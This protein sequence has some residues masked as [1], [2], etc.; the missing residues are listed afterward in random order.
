MTSFPYSIHIF[1]TFMLCSYSAFCTFNNTSSSNYPV[2]LSS[3]N[4][5]PST[6]PIHFT[7]IPS[8]FPPLLS[9]SYSAFCIFN[10]T[11]S[12][13]YPPITK[14]LPLILSTL[15]PP[16]SSVFIFLSVPAT[17]LPYSPLPPNLST[18]PPPLSP[19]VILPST[20]SKIYL[21]PLIQLSFTTTLYRLLFIS[22]FP[23]PLFSL[24]LYSLFIF[25]LLCLCCVHLPYNCYYTSLHVIYLLYEAY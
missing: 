21:Y 2:Q 5:I 19:V 4:K 3:Y 8:T 13:T 11:S 14:S 16:L 18:F 7:L 25:C 24:L 1:S 6:Y 10:N 12:S 9:C 17:P 23:P 20:V 15:P 22:L